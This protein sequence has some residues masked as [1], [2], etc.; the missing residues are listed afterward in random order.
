MK[1][2]TPILVAGGIAA[3]VLFLSM[4]PA[5]AQQTPQYPPDDELANEPAPWTVPGKW[6]RR[7]FERD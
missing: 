3:G 2:L 5:S 1:R 4:A 6:D 7:S